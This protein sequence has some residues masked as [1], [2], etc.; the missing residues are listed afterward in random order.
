MNAGEFSILVQLAEESSNYSIK[1]Y[2]KQFF[3]YMEKNL[4]LFYVHIHIWRITQ[5]VSSLFG[6]T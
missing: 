1:Y 6:I 3:Y 4:A 5:T 2:E